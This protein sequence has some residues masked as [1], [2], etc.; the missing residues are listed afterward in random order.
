LP[1]LLIAAAFILSIVFVTINPIYAQ[2]TEEPPLIVVFA[3][4]GIDAST[5]ELMSWVTIN[6]VTRTVFYN[7]TAVDLE[8]T[9]RDGMI[10][11]AITLPNGTSQVGDRFSACTVVPKFDKMECDIGFKSPTGRA[12]FFSVPLSSFEKQ[13]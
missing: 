9:A 8:D 6:N 7:A 5:G 11:T 2:T 12:E 13:Q 4:E 10:E 1:A 3:V